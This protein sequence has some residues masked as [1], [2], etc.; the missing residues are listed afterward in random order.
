MHLLVCLATIKVTC[1]TTVNA[2]LQPNLV[3]GNQISFFLSIIRGTSANC[4]SS[5]NALEAFL[6][7]AMFSSIT[8]CTFQINTG[9]LQMVTNRLQNE[10]PSKETTKNIKIDTTIAFDI[11]SANHPACFE[12]RDLVRS[13]LKSTV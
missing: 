6:G 12:L 3:R 8:G 9:P 10:L 7:D 1:D 13:F 11:C 5:T 4:S 2:R